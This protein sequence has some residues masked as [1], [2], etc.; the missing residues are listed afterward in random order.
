MEDK[1]PE[2]E[3]VERLPWHKPELDRLVISLNTNAVVPK[4][5]SYED[6]EIPGAGGWA[7]ES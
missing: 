4:S 6:G 1:S 3:S 7:V 2:T 5:L